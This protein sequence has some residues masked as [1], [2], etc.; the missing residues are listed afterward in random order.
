[1]KALIST[2]LL[3]LFALNAFADGIKTV[4]IDGADYTNIDSV[5]IG[6]NGRIM[7]FSSS[8]GV[9]SSAD[10]LPR[11]FLK[12]WGI[13]VDSARSTESKKSAG[14]MLSL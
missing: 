11:E 3:S 10:K 2:F 8:G 7:I 4:Q 6:S 13:D 9:S 14:T 1:M 5:Y 12:S